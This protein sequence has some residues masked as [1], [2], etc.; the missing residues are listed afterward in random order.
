MLLELVRQDNYLTV[1]IA[2]VGALW[3]FVFVRNMWI[4]NKSTGEFRHQYEQI[5]NA[6]EYK[7]KGKFEQ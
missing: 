1:L 7:V 6:E 3:L 4:L 2:V 5:I